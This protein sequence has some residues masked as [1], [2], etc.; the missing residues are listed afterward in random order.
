MA[1][2]PGKQP[3]PVRA[4]IGVLPA[5]RRHTISVR[6]WRARLLLAAAA[7]A[8]FLSLA[9]AW[10][11]PGSGAAF[12]RKHAFPTGRRELMDHYCDQ[13]LS[14]SERLQ[15]LPAL[16][17]ACE[18]EVL[19][20]GRRRQWQKSLA[21]IQ[22]MIE[23]GV[24]RTTGVYTAAMRA[25]GSLDSKNWQ[26]SMHL[27]QEMRQLELL[28][29]ADTYRWAIETCTRAKRRLQALELVEHMRAAELA[30]DKEV[31]LAAMR[32]CA[33]GGLWEQAIGLLAQW[34]EDGYPPN[35]EA[36]N[37]V[38]D[39][40]EEAEEYEWSDVVEDEASSHGFEIKL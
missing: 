5:Q 18:E 15:T 35:Q 24:P 39:A 13:Q 4:A 31:Y 12:A 33:G 22:E 2:P 17:D 20:W 29:D 21:I 7:L 23:R 28:P 38:L 36:Y 8:L 11:T 14:K 40:C 27:F 34:H 3:W 25:C 37:T 32:C 10:P 16:Q 19:K 1:C 9:S 30:P 6:A 26:K